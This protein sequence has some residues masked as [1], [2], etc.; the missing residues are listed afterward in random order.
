MN[1]LDR[2][3]KAIAD[4]LNSTDNIDIGCTGSL[5]IIGA[6]AIERLRQAY[7][8]FIGVQS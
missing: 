8:S 6:D 5:T 4:V 3:L 2:L 7:D 1:K